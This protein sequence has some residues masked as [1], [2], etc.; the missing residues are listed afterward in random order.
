MLKRYLA[1]AIAVAVLAAALSACGSSSGGSSSTSEHAEATTKAPAIEP[2]GG[3]K[4]SA[5]EPEG[6]TEESSASTGPNPEIKSIIE[7]EIFGRWGG[8]ATE[9]KVAGGACKIE[10]INTSEAAIKAGGEAIL[11][12]EH[13]A[14]VLVAPLKGNGGASTA[15]ECQEAIAI[16]IG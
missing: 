14:S 3:A 10:K 8:T 4:V 11:N 15:T 7:R 9:F 12:S 16:A 6:G 2:E 1:F 5:S 13:N